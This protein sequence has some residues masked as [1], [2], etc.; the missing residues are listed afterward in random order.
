MRY[1]LIPRYS[2]GSPAVVDERTAE[3]VV[4]DERRGYQ[5]ALEGVYGDDA[6]KAAKANGLEGIVIVSNRRKGFIDCITGREYGDVPYTS[7]R[8]PE[9]LVVTT[10]GRTSKYYYR[11]QLV[12]ALPGEKSRLPDANLNAV[13]QKLQEMFGVDRGLGENFDLWFN[14]R[15]EY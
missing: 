13:S 15:R 6:A 2:G 5:I 10:K 7:I 11:R 1:E 9:S 8:Y 3:S 12:A 14:R 4:R